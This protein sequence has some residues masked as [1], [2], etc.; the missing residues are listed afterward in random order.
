MVSHTIGFYTLNHTVKFNVMDGSSQPHNLHTYVENQRTKIRPHY[1]IVTAVI[2][3][4][5]IYI[6]NGIEICTNIYNKDTQLTPPQP[7]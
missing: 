1:L 7:N 4:P 6:Y 3:I 5:I 2:F